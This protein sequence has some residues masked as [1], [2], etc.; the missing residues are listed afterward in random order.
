MSHAEYKF[1]N[2]SIKEKV[3]NSFFIVIALYLFSII[4]SL[5]AIFFIEAVPEK[6]ETVLKYVSA[7]FLLIMAVLSILLTIRQA[8]WL[9]FYIVEPVKELEIASKEISSGNLD[10]QIK[11]ESKDEIGILANSLQQTTIILKKIIGDLNKILGEFSKGN[12][13]VHSEC[14]EVYVGDFKLVM[15]QLINTVNNIQDVMHLIQNSSNQVAEGTEE[16]SKLALDIAES[17]AIQ[18]NSVESLLLNMEDV[19]NKIVE[20]SKS[21]DIVHDKAKEVGEEA[22]I[23][24]QKMDKLVE[25]MERISIT[26]SKIQ[27]VITQIEDIASQTNLLSLNASIE[28][29]RAGE[30]GRGFAVVAEQIQKLAID[31]ANSAEASRLLLEDN[32]HEVEVGNKM[33]QETASSQN[34]VIEELDKIVIEVAKIRIASDKQAIS[35]KEIEMGVRKI[36][37]EIQKNSAASEEVSATCQELSAEAESLDSSVQRFQ[38]QERIL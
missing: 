8:K 34:K 4:V 35:A 7:V 29:A 33:V 1:Q 15:D 26:S 23:S 16:F 5:L 11:Y 3:Q 36:N 32:Q 24:K 18:A 31:S 21:T 12:F 6:Y 37:E 30:F 10:I 28:A 14:K 27:K 9:I 22:E 17:A 2:E 13:K 19:T 25:A 38:L 20:N